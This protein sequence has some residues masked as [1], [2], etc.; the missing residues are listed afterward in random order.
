MDSYSIYV[1]FRGAEV[2]AQ[3]QDFG[4]YQLVNFSDNAV[5]NDFTGTLKFEGRK[6]I[7]GYIRNKD[8]QDLSE[9][10]RAIEKQLR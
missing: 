4:V 2:K 1:R 3:V 8:A 6:Y 10:T 9:L 7:P 5:V